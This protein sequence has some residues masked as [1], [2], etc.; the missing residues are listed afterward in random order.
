MEEAHTTQRRLAAILSADVAGYSRMM[1]ADEVATV[2]EVKRCREIIDTHVREHHGRIVDAPGD[3]VL[4]EFPSAVEAVQCAVEVQRELAA[5]N[6]DLEPARRM[7]FRIG[8]HV[9][10]VI[11]EDGK[12][13]GD[14]VNIAARLEALAPVGGICISAAVHEQIR[15]KLDIDCEDLGEQQ[16]KNIPRPVRVLRVRMEKAPP[17]PARA[18]SSSRLRRVTPILGV[19]AA[20]VL[21]AVAGWKFFGSVPTGRPPA[22]NQSLRSLAVL[23]LENLSGDPSQEFFADGM[24]EE[25]ITDLAKISALRVISRTSVMQFKGEHRKPLPEI[26]KMLNVDAVIEGSVLRVGDKVRIT[27]Q[28]IDAPNDKHLWAQSYERDS[29]D[30]LAMQD[31]VAS[32]IANQVNVALTPQEREHLTSSSP[33]NP[34]AYEAYLKGR[35]YYWLDTAEAEDKAL[36]YV[37]QSINIDPTFSLGYVGLSDYY[38]NAI[39]W[40]YAPNVA[41]PKAREFAVKALELNPSLAEAHAALGN[42]KYS[43]D[44][45]WVGAE[46]EFR[47]AIELSPGYVGAHSYYGQML[48]SQGRFVESYSELERARQLDPM[49]ATLTMNV[50]FPLEQLGQFDK[51]DSHCRQGAELAPDFWLTHTCFSAFYGWMGKPQESIAEAEKVVATQSDPITLAN[52]GISYALSGNREGAE[53]LIEL[54]DKQSRTS[55]AYISPCAAALIHLGLGHNQQALDLFEKCYQERSQ[56]ILSLKADPRL[57]PLRADPRFI[58][59]LKKIGLDNPADDYVAQ[60]LDAYGQSTPD[61][62]ARARKLFQAAIDLDPKHALATAGLGTTLWYPWSV[63]WDSDSASLD[64]ALELGRQAVAINELQPV[65]HMLLASAYASKGQHEQAIDEGQRATAIYPGAAY[66]FDTFAA[67]LNYSGRPAE[68]IEQLKKSTQLDARDKHL[69]LLGWS[70]SLSGRYDE[71]IAAEKE[72]VAHNPNPLLPHVVLAFD[73]AQLGKLDAARAESKEILRISPKYTTDGMRRHAPYKDANET[74]RW[75]SALR[76]AGLN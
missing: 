15:G 49:S 27:A 73:Y 14:G 38:W 67:V 44:F 62:N 42:V 55:N 23:P 47:R 59:L 8:I 10:D 63:Q 54:L 20:V 75:A 68:A 51:A 35:Y 46:A 22:A 6:G 28:L 26:A 24:T 12:I 4:A 16:V 7:E 21:L 31:E 9:G 66:P 65:G 45:D 74:D 25:L 48:L 29:R 33:V 52:L 18:P 76:K 1:A 30:V 36:Q 69:D 58:E 60:G 13:Y 61:G 39:D 72:F 43:Y 64:R 19:A 3:N 5:H 17:A 56:M 50:S 40:R 70:Y 41:I 71:S 32:A 53:K 37:Q 11:L 34:A 57:T 2:R